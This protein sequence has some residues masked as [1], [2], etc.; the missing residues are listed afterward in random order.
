MYKVLLDLLVFFFRKL[1]KR[2][3][4]NFPKNVREANISKEQGGKIPKLKIFEKR[5]YLCCYVA[6]S[7]SVLREK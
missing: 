4:F 6:K 2:K 1:W 7:P 3:E 5:T